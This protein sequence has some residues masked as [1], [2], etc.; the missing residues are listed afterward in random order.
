MKGHGAGP[1]LQVSNLSRSLKY[2]TDVLGFTEDFRFGAERVRLAKPEE[3]LAACRKVFQTWPFDR[4]LI[5]PAIAP[6]ISGMC[7]VAFTMRSGR[8][9]RSA[10]V[11]S[12]NASVYLAV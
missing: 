12:R 10:L 2:Y 11:S 8:S 6:T 1:V 7:S 9:R 5:R 3:T 4:D